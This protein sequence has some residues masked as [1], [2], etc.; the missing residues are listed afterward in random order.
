VTADHVYCYLV[1]RVF[2]CKNWGFH[3]GEDTCCG[4]LDYESL[5]KLF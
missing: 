4:L 3:G 5:F 1:F 2:V